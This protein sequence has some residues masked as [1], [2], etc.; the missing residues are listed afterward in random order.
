MNKSYFKYLIIAFVVFSSC[1]GG[2][3]D[4]SIPPAGVYKNAKWL[5][6]KDHGVWINI[7][8]QI[9]SNSF[10]IAVYSDGGPIWK[11]DIFTIDEKCSKFFINDEKDLFQ[12]LLYF[13]GTNF[14]LKTINPNTNKYCLLYA[15]RQISD[16]PSFYPDCDN[17]SWIR[18]V[19]KGY[20]FCL[21]KIISDSVYSISLWN[22]EGELKNKGNYSFQ[23]T[24]NIV[25]DSI[26]I[27]DY[28]YDFD[29]LDIILKIDSVKV[30]L[31]MK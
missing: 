16:K 28:I 21:N 30:R 19:T 20:W 13:D 27:T 17:A 12:N 2:K 6:G 24:N 9:D 31:T 29:N 18:G 10:L 25:A 7:K 1:K 4:R 11:Q 14:G 8:E 3:V 15:S 5:G 22:H 26:N 23:S